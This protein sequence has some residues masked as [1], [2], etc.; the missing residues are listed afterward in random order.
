MLQKRESIA[1]SRRRL[2]CPKP[3]CGEVIT[4]DDI[5]KYLDETFYSAVERWYYTKLWGLANGNIG[6]ANEP[7]DYMDVIT[8]IESEQNA[9]EHE[10]TTKR[11]E[12]SKKKSSAP[13]KK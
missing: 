3:Y 9:I 1:V 7:K 12:E 10:E 4:W 8:L 5:P 11:M 2:P 6:W 13:K